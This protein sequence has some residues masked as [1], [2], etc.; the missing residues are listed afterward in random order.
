LRYQPQQS[1]DV[2]A[3]DHWRVACD[4]AAKLSRGH[5]ANLRGLFRRE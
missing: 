3:A 4:L 1:A 5:N 2:A